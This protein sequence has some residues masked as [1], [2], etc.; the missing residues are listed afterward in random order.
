MRP[1]TRREL[2]ADGVVHAGGIVLGVVGFGS[3]LIHLAAA[4]RWPR[5]AAAAVG[6]YGSSLLAMLVCSAAYNV[7]QV[8][9]GKHRSKLALLDHTGI[10][11]VIAGTF[12]PVM[13]VACQLHAALLMWA[14]MVVT[15]TAKALGGKL[16]SIALH[17][18]AFVLGPVLIVLSVW[19]DVVARLDPWEAILI[20]VGGAF[21]IGGLLPWGCRGLE[22][23]VAIWHVC[24]L[25]GSGC[26]FAIVQH[27]VFSPDDV[28]NLEAELQLCLARLWSQ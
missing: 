2:L 17:V 10:C 23:H 5:L 22:G 3:L 7:G 20:W 26:F 25:L 27:R 16:D 12:T 21:Y 18:S 15:V 9:W 28:A 6:V 4:P 19:R 8:S 24:V 14:L 13:A 11:L 1:Y